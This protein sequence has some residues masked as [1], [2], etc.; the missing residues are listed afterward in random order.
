MAD[1]QLDSD[2]RLLLLAGHVQ[3]LGVVGV[4]VG[5]AGSHI[6]LEENF[7]CVNPPPS[8]EGPAGIRTLKKK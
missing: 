5:G 2:K 8:N 7:P 3:E 1:Y 6:L 4:P